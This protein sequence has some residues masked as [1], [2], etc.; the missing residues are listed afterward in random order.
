MF[1]PANSTHFYFDVQGLDTSAKLQVLSFEGV[2]AISSDYAV[3][4]TLVC[5]HL[6]FDITKLL[7]KPAFLSFDGDKSTGIHGTIQ[8]VKRAAIGNHYATFKVI[9]TPT[10]THLKKRVNQRVFRTKTVPQIISTILSEYGL[11]EGQDFS[12]RLKDSSVYTV[13]EYTTQ[14]DQSDYDFI[15]HLAESEG[16]FY[17]FTHTKEGHVIT[18]ADANP[19]FASLADAIRYQVDTGLHTDQRVIK[20]FDINVSSCTTEAS[21]RQYNFV[22]MKIPE[23]NAKGTQSEKENQAIEPSLES[24]DYPSRHLNKKEGDRLSLIEIERLRASQV[25]AEADSDVVGLHAGFFISITN[26]PLPDTEKPWLIREIR[27]AGKQPSVLEAFGEESTANSTTSAS[28]L[29]RYFNYP[30]SKALEFP[31]EDFNQGYRNVSIL[32]PRDVAYRPQKLHLKPKVLGTQTAII[33]GAAGEEIYCDEYGRVKIQCHWDREGQYNENSSDWVRVASNWAHKSYGAIAIPRV[34]MEVLVEY[35]EGDPDFPIVVGALHNGVNKVPYELPTHKT[36]SVFKTSSSKGGVGSNEFRVEDKA[37]QEQIFVQA[38]KD[39]DQLTKHNHTITVGHNSHLQVQ[40]E[41]SE[42]IIG[43]R[44]QEQQ[45][46]E[47]H[48]TLKDRKTQIML[49]DYKMV[50]ESSH[51]TIG[52]VLTTEAGIEIHLKASQQIVID[53]GLSLTLKAG[54]QHIVL[55]PSGI[56]TTPIFTGGIPM[57]GTP[58]IPIS[59]PD[60]EIVDIWFSHSD[61]QIKIDDISRFYV[62]LNVHILTKNYRE[63]ELVKATINTGTEE[64]DVFGKVNEANQAVV[65]N[66]FQNRGVT[67]SSVKS[68]EDVTSSD[69]TE[70]SQEIV[71]MWFS[72][73]DEHT[74]VADVSRFYTDLNLHILTKN[75][76]EGDLVKATIETDDE[77]FDVFA[78]VNNADEAIATNIF[79]DKKF[80]IKD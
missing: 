8:S 9:L 20:R 12:F 26:H 7:T 53:G 46:E 39:F 3:E 52:T 22:N 70:N 62:D 30:L 65:T 27:H 42:T 1:E 76:Q 69:P 38:Q 2:E 21:F 23:G 33:C 57:E 16:L 14:Y 31:L 40:N 68:S 74:K 44:Y 10:L 24:Y 55:N 41:H 35:Q 48:L 36:R 11:A 78:T 25:L 13:R 43:N 61:E 59:S 64:F 73:G 51:A 63:G 66:I 75:Y 58:A 56:F 72:Y 67:I 29:Y 80:V 6:R 49:N 54:G 18:F 60:K 28:Q 71:D 15:N 32:S 79:N 19:F 17:F 5:D 34:G 37:D 47:H 4:I 50:T 77:Q 45:A